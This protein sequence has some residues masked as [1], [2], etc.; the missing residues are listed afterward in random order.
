MA[1]KFQLGKFIASGSIEVE[2]RFDVHGD[3]LLSGSIK[4]GNANADEIH[5]K[6]GQSRLL[7]EHSYQMKAS[8]AEAVAF[9]Q[10]A[11]DYIVV[12]TAG[13]GSVIVG[14]RL[15]GHAGLA[16]SGSLIKAEA[17]ELNKLDGTNAD[18]SAAKLNSLSALTDTE[19]GYLDGA[20]TNN[21]VA[22]KVAMLDGSRKLLGIAELSASGDVIG[23]HGKAR[24]ITIGYDGAGGAEGH[25]K[26]GAGGDMQLAVFS[27]NATILNNTSNK[28]IVFQ[29][30]QGSENFSPLKVEG[31]TR[32][33]R[34]DKLS[35]S[36]TL[37]TSDAGELNLLDGAS[38]GNSVASKAVILD[39]SRH[40][41]GI[42]AVSSS[43]DVK[44]G[45]LVAHRLGMADDTD[46][47]TLRN[48][49]IDV[50]SNAD[51]DIKKTGGLKLEGTA[52]TST[53]AELNKLDGAGGSVTA[54][55]LTTLSD[56][57][58]A[59]I[60]YLDGATAGTALASKAVVLDANK[61]VTGIKNVTGSAFVAAAAGGFFGQNGFTIGSAGQPDAIK[62]E[63]TGV[64]VNAP[65]KLNNDLHVSGSIITVDAQNSLFYD[66]LI[67][68]GFASGSNDRAVGDRGFIFGLDAEDDVALYWDESNSYFAV[69]KTT[70]STTGS[71]IV[72]GDYSDFRVNKLIAATVEATIAE[73]VQTVS[74]TS[75]LNA[76]N[77]TIV[78][79]DATGGDRVLTLPAANHSSVSGVILKFK[80]INTNANKFTIH[81][82]GS[83][84]IDGQ[85]ALVLESSYAAVNLI[86]DGTDKYYVM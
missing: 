33:V 51:F 18:V 77:G 17:A 48:Q 42:V 34:I 23:G 83:D 5:I 58:D 36:G 82:A 73:T 39:G 76:A 16:I 45:G 2:D 57:T 50:A 54:A 75:T 27:D 62:M 66:N 65:L 40:I 8:S 14:A 79:L 78:L 61:D 84:E 44:T 20:V 47:L 22:T 15:D 59:E 24:Q 49:A 7:E 53:A 13:T 25:L 19:I 74:T 70:T 52:V 55:K 1:Y 80:K 31:A 68:L 69:S 64:V 30:K 26:L 67:G 6:A 4:L 56:L 81:R 43:T 9:S 35:L 38:D 86:S 28:D 21:S 37:V 46:L 10:G 41:K 63:S 85:H 29:V 3:T 72:P 11:T 71:V 60:G 32:Q 12:S